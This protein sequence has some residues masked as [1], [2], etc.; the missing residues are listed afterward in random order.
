MP[1]LFGAEYQLCALSNTVM[2]WTTRSQ[3]SF[4]PGAVSASTKGGRDAKAPDT[5]GTA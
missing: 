4:C 5:K 2:V 3:V 1:F